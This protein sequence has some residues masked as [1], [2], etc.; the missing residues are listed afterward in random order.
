V[1]FESQG[2]DGEVHIWSIDADGG[3]LR[4]LSTGLGPQV[5]ASW[6]RDGQW[7]YYS[8]VRPHDREI[9]RARDS[10]TP[11]ERVTKGGGFVSE[12]SADGRTLYY[13]P[14]AADG[15]LLAQALAGGPPSTVIACVA[16][17][18]FAAGRAGI[19]YLPCTQPAHESN[20]AVHLFDPGSRTDREL[21]RLEGFQYTSLPS[22][23]AP[24]PDGRSILYG[25][26]IRDGS[27]LMVIDGFH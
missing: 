13:L 11:P 4:Q 16:A 1:A 25:R 20:P 7:V 15:P 23:F 19:Y 2:S 8:W 27:D 9:W 10:A 3:T 14:R 17:T 21:G 12:E 22:G 18:A 24:S 26:Q 5:T 6:S